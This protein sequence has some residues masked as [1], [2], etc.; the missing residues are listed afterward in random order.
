MTI[1]KENF[2][3]EGTLPVFILRVKDDEGNLS[4]LRIQTQHA[5]CEKSISA[6]GSAS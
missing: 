3:K 5:D 1:T 6:R 2:D 4:E